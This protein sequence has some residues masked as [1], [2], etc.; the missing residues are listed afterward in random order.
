MGQDGGRSRAV[1]FDTYK[2]PCAPDIPPI[3]IQLVENRDGPGPFGAK[4]IGE[5]AATPTAP[6]IT[7]AV[8]DAIGVRIFDLPV[9]AEK[10]LEGILQGW[11]K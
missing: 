7:N 3:S 4:G 9:T 10:V 1:N 6:A 2:M 5:I 8:E 11:N